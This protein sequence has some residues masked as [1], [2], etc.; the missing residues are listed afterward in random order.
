[1]KAYPGKFIS[2]EGIEGTG[3]STVLK[4]IKEYFVVNKIDHL[5]TREPGG[6]PIAEAIRNVLLSHY[7]EKMCSETELL[8]YFAGRAQHLAVHVLPALEQGKIVISDRY[9]DASYAY[10]GGGRGIALEKIDA[11]VS[12]LPG[13]LKPNMTL[14]FDA[15]VEV[16]MQRMSRRGEKDRIEIEKIEFFERVRKTYLVRA[17]KY[18]EQFRIIDAT[19]SIKTVSDK[20]ISF[21]QELL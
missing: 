18:P 4:A 7:E 9:V 2:I 21:I 10:Q 6:T 16:G 1:M 8:L 19:Q 17:K 11:L 14:L 12:V 15:P 13:N 3:K 5:I 20:A